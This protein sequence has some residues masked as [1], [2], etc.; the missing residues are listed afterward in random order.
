M[1]AKGC[2]FDNQKQ[3]FTFCY[4]IGKKSTRKLPKFLM[5]FQ[6]CPV[7][8]QKM[9][10][11][12]SKSLNMDKNRLGEYNEFQTLFVELQ[13][14]LTEWRFLETIGPSRSVW[15]GE[16]FRAALTYCASDTELGVC[17]KC[18]VES[19][20]IWVA[21]LVSENTVLAVEF[22]NHLVDLVFLAD[23]LGEFLGGFSE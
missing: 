20:K 22:S 15:T 1:V 12:V 13:P 9:Q 23:F 18:V 6:F 19:P 17:P 16:T 11:K 5:I 8:V 10:E 3:F 7:Y 2:L 21:L 4:K 14:I